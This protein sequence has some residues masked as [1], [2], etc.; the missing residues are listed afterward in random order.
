M[1]PVGY[2]FSLIS[3]NQ[4]MQK[5]G[6]KFQKKP[7]L[8]LQFLNCPLQKSNCTSISSEDILK[9][10]KDVGIRNTGKVLKIL[11][12]LPAENKVPAPEKAKVRGG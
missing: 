9:M 6:K 2:V 10:S 1:L 4:E 3:G 8:Q 11:K 7:R 12:Y 5:T